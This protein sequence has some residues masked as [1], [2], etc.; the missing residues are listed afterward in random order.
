MIILKIKI[1]KSFL[2]ILDSMIK[3]NNQKT[4]R[5]RIKKIMIN[6]MIKCRYKNHRKRRKK[7]SNSLKIKKKSNNL[8]KKMKTKVFIIK[9]TSMFKKISMSFMKVQDSLF[10]SWSIDM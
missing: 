9:K 6:Q 2:N 5:I 8:K 4:K 10:H 7:Q 1:I 3:K